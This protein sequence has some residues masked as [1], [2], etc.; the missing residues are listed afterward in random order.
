[1]LYE[2]YI[3]AYVKRRRFMFRSANLS[4]EHF[5]SKWHLPIKEDFYNY[6]ATNVLGI[7]YANLPDSSEKEA[8][9]EEILK[10][11]HGF[12]IKYLNMIVRGH[13]PPINSS[14]GMEAIK[15]LNLLS[16]IGKDKKSNAVYGEICRT[17]HLAFKQSSTDDIYDSLLMCLMRAVKKY[18]PRYVEKLRNVCEAIDSK[19]KGKHKKVGTVPEFTAYD[20]ASK[21]GTDVNSYLRKLVKRGHLHSI[22]D[23]KKKVIGYRRDAKN[24]P[25]SSVLFKNG[26]VGFTYAVQTY[27]RFYLH[28][29]I[30]RQM[31]SIESKEGMLQ[32]D[33]RSPGDLSWS[34]MGDPGTP[35]S[36][37]AFTDTDG[38]NWAADTLLMSLPLDVSTMDEDWVAS[39]DDKLFRGLSKTERNILYLIYVKEYSISQIATI[40]GVDPKAVRSK[41]DDIMISLKS[42]IDKNK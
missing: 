4:S 10:C 7:R 26:P 12:L 13:L 19:C 5:A 16:S 31:H 40:I 11:W 8:L 6:E 1:M 37:G 17:L 33:H 15:F 28:E 30:T 14:A 24:W 35:H 21:V 27:F 34:T 29:Y 25:P 3:I 20:I 9:L 42:I 23:Q 2:K 39:T 22:A 41:R 36:E 18:D 38:H 32:L